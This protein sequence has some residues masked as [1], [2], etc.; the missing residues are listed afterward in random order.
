MLLC[1]AVANLSPED[2]MVYLAHCRQISGLDQRRAGK[3]GGERGQ[4]DL[5]T[6]F[7]KGGPWTFYA[8]FLTASAPRAPPLFI[9]CCFP[10]SPRGRFCSLPRLWLLVARPVAAQHPVSATASPCAGGL[11]VCRRAGSKAGE[12]TKATISFSPTK[13][14][15]FSRTPVGVAN[16]PALS[17]LSR[18]RLSPLN[19]PPTEKTSKP[20]Q[21]RRLPVRPRSSPF[22]LLWDIP[23]TTN[24]SLPVAGD[25][26]SRLVP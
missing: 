3:R 21:L 10:S 25:M 11:D 22:L 1:A 5:A 7:Q 13:L 15:A 26:R 24:H 23:F 8:P 2:A 9:F 19:D 16:P 18:P 20:P 12:H 4:V 17:A 14:R 6:W